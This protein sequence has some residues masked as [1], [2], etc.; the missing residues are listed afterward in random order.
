VAIPGVLRGYMN[1]LEKLE[2]RS[3]KTEVRR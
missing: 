2:V 3:E 1:G